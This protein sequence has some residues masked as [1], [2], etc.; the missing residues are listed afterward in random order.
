MISRATVEL[1]GQHAQIFMLILTRITAMFGAS[2]FFRQETIPIRMR[3]SFSVIL[4]FFAMLVHGIHGPLLSIPIS[5]FY[6]MLLTQAFLGILIAV[7]LNLFIEVFLVLG[8]L[9]SVQA[10]LGFVSLYVPGMGTISA[11]SHFFTL[12]ATIL[13]LELN[14][15]LALFK[16]LIESI[17]ANW[18]KM[19]H[20]NL[21][22]LKDIALFMKV[23]FSAG[24]L[25][26]L[27]ILIALLV[28][29]MTLG[30]MTKFAP[31]IN[32]LSIGINI[33]LILCFC[34]VYLAFD[35]ILENGDV[36]LN[37]LLQYTDYVDK[38][39]IQYE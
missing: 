14:G 4:S 24:L 23:I 27:S 13:F 2:M 35:A 5:Q 12:T 32:I 19:G 6:P 30:F 15:H 16:L 10:G 25:M 26:A 21:E 22:M 31:Q 8:Q 37:D 36:L 39:V 18:A 20:V 7:V 38:R 29:N 33:T 9:V 34:L 1:I 17:D 11:L 3:I 28:A